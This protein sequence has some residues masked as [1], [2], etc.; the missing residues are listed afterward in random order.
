MT[1]IA[2]TQT[3]TIHAAIDDVWKALTTPSAIEQWFFGVQTET[4]WQPGNSIVHTGEWQGKPYQD[5]GTIL[6]FEP[7]MLLVH[8]HW[9]AMSGL[10]DE[11]EHYQEVR[12]ELAER[13]GVTELTLHET[14]LPSKDAKAVS[15]QAWAAALHNLKDLLETSEVSGP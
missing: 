3:V 4:D 7:P 8:T 2:T 9:S 13:D 5:K 10:P 11:P 15:D 12:W 1:E 14:N 6:Q